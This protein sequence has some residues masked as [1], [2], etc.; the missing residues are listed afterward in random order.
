MTY[1]L[2]AG[3]PLMRYTLS[4][5]LAGGAFRLAARAVAGGAGALRQ[6]LLGAARS[7]A[8]RMRGGQRMAGFVRV[9]VLRGCVSR[10]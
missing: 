4:T 3:S 2:K 5:T 7:D 1:T 6:A 10:A 8:A 9:C